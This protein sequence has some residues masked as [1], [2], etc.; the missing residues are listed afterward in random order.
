MAD[1]LNNTDRKYVTTS[2][3]TSYLCSA[4][5]IQEVMWWNPSHEYTKVLPSGNAKQLT[6][7]FFQLLRMRWPVNI[8]K[9]ALAPK[10][11]KV[12]SLKLI[13]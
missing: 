2:I 3:Q 5:V 8:M 6:L 1:Y 13:L 7:D 11:R 10:H 4:D 9:L 12:S